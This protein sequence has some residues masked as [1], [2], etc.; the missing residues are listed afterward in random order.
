MTRK[1]QSTKQ[2]TA[3]SE[4]KE[5]LRHVAPADEVAHWYANQRQLTS[6]AK[7]D[8]VE[9]DYGRT[10]TDNFS[11]DGPLCWSYQTVIA[12]RY[13]EHGI[14]LVSEETYSNT[15]SRHLS[16]V[17]SAFRGHDIELVQVPHV[18][19]ESNDEHW[20]NLAKLRRDVHGLIKSYRRGYRYM[21]MNYVGNGRW[22]DIESSM[23]TWLKYARAFGLTKWFSKAE[24]EI[25]RILD[26]KREFESVTVDSSLL[27][28]CTCDADREDI[29]SILYGQP[30]EREDTL[31]VL[32]GFSDR[33][34]ADDEGDTYLNETDLYDQFRKR[35][36]NRYGF[37]I[38]RRIS[39]DAQNKATREFERKLS[40]ADYARLRKMSQ[41]ERIALWQ[42]GETLHATM[43]PKRSY[44]PEYFRRSIMGTSVVW[45]SEQ[46]RHATRR[47]MQS[48]GG[49]SQYAT[50]RESETFRYV[51]KSD[52]S[53]AGYFETS[54]KVKIPKRE[55]IRVY[56]L[57]RKCWSVRNDRLAFY[58]TVKRVLA[59]LKARKIDRAY[60]VESIDENGWIKA[61]CHTFHW[62]ELACIAYQSGIA[63]SL[64]KWNQL[65]LPSPETVN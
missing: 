18:Q 36:K 41:N 7:Y 22:S 48:R 57:L 21:S 12:R 10:S 28:C 20:A 2:T 62:D 54:Q 9:C 60:L 45:D 25:A 4:S 47:E 6:N 34:D 44:G 32:F 29:Q 59:V 27:D 19:P 50:Q 26:G 13:D 40:S 56:A 52:S 65:C 39:V 55:A 30:S 35:L 14:V 53:Q 17:Q 3:R 42:S 58:R 46:R 61:G 24:R 15:T 5:S 11:F 1:A 38:N 23:R 64:E 33:N 8:D 49:C 31:R 63:T 51:S 37:E 16:N 43:R